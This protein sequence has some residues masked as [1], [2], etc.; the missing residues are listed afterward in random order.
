MVLIPHK[1]HQFSVPGE[2]DD[3][4][5]F[6]QMKHASSSTSCTVLLKEPANKY[7]SPEKFAKR[8]L[9]PES[10][11]SFCPEQKTS[12]MMANGEVLHLRQSWLTEE[13]KSPALLI[14]R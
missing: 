3:A 6:Y 14:E 11:P 5:R 2:V 10:F 12:E 9:T 1:S 7:F 8:S 13:W 4:A